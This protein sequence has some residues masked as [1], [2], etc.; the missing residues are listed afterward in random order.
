MLLVAVWFAKR[1]FGRTIIA[2]GDNPTTAR[3]SGTRSWWVKTSTFIVSSLSATLLLGSTTTW[4][5]WLPVPS[6]ALHAME[7]TVAAPPVASFAI[8]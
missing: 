2:L 5:V 1:P 8:V 3:F 4:M 6:F 7:V